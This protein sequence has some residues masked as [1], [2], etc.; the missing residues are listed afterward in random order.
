LSLDGVATLK[1]AGTEV[2]TLADLHA[3]VILVDDALA[4]AGAG[5][6]TGKG[7]GGGLGDNVELGVVLRADQRRAAETLMRKWW[8]AAD[9]VDEDGLRRCRAQAKRIRVPANLPPPHALR[10]RSP[11]TSLGSETLASS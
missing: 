10:C 1:Q 9:P 7:L 8:R 11:D 2:R 5:N 4:V 3:K 6:L